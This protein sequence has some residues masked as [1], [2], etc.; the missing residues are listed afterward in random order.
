M[1]WHS[2][3]SR[4]Q[5]APCARFGWFVGVFLDAASG[6]CS[7][8]FVYSRCGHE[9]ATGGRGGSD[10]PASPGSA[11]CT[12]ALPLH[13]SRLPTKQRAPSGALG[14]QQRAPF[15]R[16]CAQRCRWK[17]R[18][19]VPC[20][21][22]LEAAAS[23]DKRAGSSFDKRAEVIHIPP[24]FDKRAGRCQPGDSGCP[25]PPTKRRV[26]VRLLSGT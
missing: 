7:W 9:W 22:K 18:Y 24:S 4:E 15:A 23:F 16:A 26:V 19:K 3:P 10:R 21:L 8:R 13:P 1:R 17:Y 6:R 2:R 12:V 5:N 11:V 25:Q 14:A 20:S